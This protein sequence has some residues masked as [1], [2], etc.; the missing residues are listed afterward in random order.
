MILKHIHIFRAAIVGALLACATTSQA[1]SLFGG[2]SKSD[3]AAAIKKADKILSRADSAYD[4]GNPDQALD[5]YKRALEIYEKLEKDFPGVEDGVAAYRIAYCGDQIAQISGVV[6]TNPPEDGQDEKRPAV[7]MPKS[8]FSLED[9]LDTPAFE[10]DTFADASANEAGAAGISPIDDPNDEG[11]LAELPPAAIAA[12]LAEAKDALDA[13]RVNDAATAAIDLLRAD[14]QNRA[15]RIMMGVI[16]TRQQRFDE[17]LVALEDVLAEEEDEAVLLAI[18]G[19]YQA[20]GRMN[21]AL[22]ALD[23]AIR[24]NPKH[25]AAFMNMAWLM[26]ASNEAKA[27]E[28]NYREAVRLGA[29]R[30]KQLERKLGF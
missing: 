15:G 19:A 24:L 2:D 22:L 4:G 18:A 21:H 5:L 23:K 25:P 17:A 12:L 10:M 1:F 6:S 14:P 11:A 26:L 20:S 29:P 27:A 28:A 7:A 16:R 9:P 3:A 30:D 13:G 8:D